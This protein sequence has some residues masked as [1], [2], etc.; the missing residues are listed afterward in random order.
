MQTTF[1]TYFNFYFSLFLFFSCQKSEKTN[2]LPIGSSHKVPVVKIQQIQSKPFLLQLQ[3]NGITKAQ[4]QTQLFFKQTGEINRINFPNTSVVSAG[5]IIAELDNRKEKLLVLQAQDQFKKASFILNKLLI[6]Y[7]GKDLDTLSIP[8]RVLEN[9]KI[10]SAYYEARTALRHAQVQYENTFLKA[11]YTGVITNLKTKEH[12][13]A[14]LSEPFC[15]LINNSIMAIE[16]FILESELSYV[17]IGQSVKIKPLAYKD[18]NYIGKVYEINPQVNQQGLVSIKIRIQNPN[19][20]LFDGMNAHI[21][22]EKSLSNQLVIPKSAIVERSGR[23]VVFTYEKGLAKWH[24]VSISHENETHMAISEGL[25]AGNWIIL[26][27]NLNLGHDAK[28]EI[29]K[30][31]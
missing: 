3:T 28:V 8:S 2:N 13:Q 30:D 10:Q 6:E 27:G 31:K 24:Y 18:K 7:G 1:L 22:I 17:Q 16:A 5:R 21:V 20:Y 15:T 11:P 25:N 29:N 4:Q 23:K 9:I 19:K 14:S 12:N 26:D